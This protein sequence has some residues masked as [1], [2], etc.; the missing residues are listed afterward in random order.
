MKKNI[1]NL[2][3]RNF[4]KFKIEGYVIP[5]NDEFFSE[6]DENNRLYKISNFSG[7][8]GLAIITKKMNYLFVDA[9]RL[10]V[11]L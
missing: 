11:F 8:A 5:K 9:V 2:L 10:R 6:F 1:I 4:S 7:S 3:K